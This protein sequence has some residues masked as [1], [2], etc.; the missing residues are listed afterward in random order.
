MG[1]S[2][3]RT[4]TK[5][6]GQMRIIEVIFASLI[7]VFALSFVSIFAAVPASTTYEVTNLERMGYS[8]LQDLDQNGLLAKF[9]YIEDWESIRAALSVSLPLDVYFKMTVYDWSRTNVYGTILYCPLGTFET[10][11]NVAS[12]TYSLVGYPKTVGGTSSYQATYN[13]RIL[14]LQL[15]RG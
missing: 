9:V 4:R 12:V 5:N 13:P 1:R 6:K 3:M 10:S 15:A 8:L 2:H 11:K 14:I 7:V